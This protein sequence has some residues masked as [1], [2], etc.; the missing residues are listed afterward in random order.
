MV[1]DKVDQWQRPWCS[2]REFEIN[3][4]VTHISTTRKPETHPEVALR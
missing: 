1:R 3:E 4:K 2:P